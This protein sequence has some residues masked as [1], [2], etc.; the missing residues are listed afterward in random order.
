MISKAMI[1]DEVALGLRLRNVSE[2][3][4]SGR[5]EKVLK[6]CGLA[7][8]KDWPISALSY[9]QKKRVTIASILVLNPKILILDEPTAGQDYRH[10]SEIMEFLLEIN[11]LGVTVIMITHDMHLMLEYTPRAIVLSGGCKIADTAAS[12]VLTDENVIKEANLKETSLY[13][14]AHMAG[15]TDGTSFVQSFIDYERWVRR[16]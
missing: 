14:L 7:P 9:G 10:Y 3:E 5:I 11:K 6:V 1:Y 15:I 12:V 13:H 8:F 4:I 16:K 2:E